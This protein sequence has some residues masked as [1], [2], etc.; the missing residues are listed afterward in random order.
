TVPI[1]RATEPGTIPDAQRT[2]STSQYS[3]RCRNAVRFTPEPPVDGP[4]AR[5]ETRLRVPRQR[6]EARPPPEPVAGASGAAARRPSRWSVQ[7]DRRQ[8]RQFDPDHAGGS[9]GDP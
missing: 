9:G 6:P 2:A 8:P 3:M 1:D 4:A 5:P 7:A